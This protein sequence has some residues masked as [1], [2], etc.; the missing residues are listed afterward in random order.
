MAE[1]RRFIESVQRAWEDLRLQSD[2][3]KV[4]LIYGKIGE[5]V[6]AE[7]DC[8][9]EGRIPSPQEVLKILE[10]CYGEKRS[11]PALQR[12]FFSNKQRPDEDIRTYSHRIK[13]AFDAVVKK[14]QDTSATVSQ[15]CELRDT[16]L[17][18]IRD[19]QMKRQLRQ[20]LS[21]SP[22]SS[23]NELR[24]QAMRWEEEDSEE[25]EEKPIRQVSASPATDT[26]AN[27]I[28]ALTDQ[29]SK[30]TTLVQ[31]QQHQLEQVRSRGTLAPSMGQQQQSDRRRGPPR[32][33]TPPRLRKG[34]LVCYA[35]GQTGHFART[36]PQVQGN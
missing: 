22:N 3:E 19:R 14:Q 28:K 23:F 31:D 33:N 7:L 27:A 30:L 8:Q 35:C 26:T 13:A 29:M 5:E 25:E 6:E 18:N 4:N 12:L 24:I 2:K 32:H 9:L 36:C 16:F 11:V 34:S 20:M 21:N 1:T 15:P 17:E 10:R